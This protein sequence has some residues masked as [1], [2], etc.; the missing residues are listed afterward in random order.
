M[1][2]LINFV[3]PKSYTSSQSLLL[4]VAR[5]AFAGLMLRHG[6]EKLMN[7]STTAEHFPALLGMDS[8]T[9]LIMAIFGEVVCALAVVVGLLTRPALLALI[10]NMG[11]AFFLAHSGSVADGEL[12]LMYLLVYIFLFWAGPGHL[13]ADGFIASRF[14]SKK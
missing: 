12:A 1:Q 10:I 9:S 8:R 14:L 11:V 5:V 13:S 3:F 6:L 2:T 7:F 4:L